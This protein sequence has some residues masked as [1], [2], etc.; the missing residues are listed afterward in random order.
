MVQNENK[1]YQWLA[2][3]NALVMLTSYCTTPPPGA[4]LAAILHLQYVVDQRLYT[5]RGLLNRSQSATSHEGG[6][7]SC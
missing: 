6:K 2:L 3:I 7:S 1:W 4:M 5:G